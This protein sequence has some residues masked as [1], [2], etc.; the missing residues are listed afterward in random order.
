MGETKAL[1][2]AGGEN[3]AL[4]LVTN[5]GGPNNVLRAANQ[6]K[7]AGNNPNLAIAKGADP[8]NVRIVLQLGGANNAAKVA[9]A[10]PKLM[11]RRRR[12]RRTTKRKSQTARPKVSAIKKLIRSLPKKKLLS[13][14]PKDNKK[15][16]E[17]KNKADV[18]TRVTSYLTG[19]TKKK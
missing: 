16:L 5:A 10:T 18:A 8:K 19:R 3:K 1:A 9:A 7:E 4:N 13:I 15:T 2:N 6:L 12:R 17:G 14:L 11:K